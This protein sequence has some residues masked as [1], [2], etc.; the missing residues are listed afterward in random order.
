MERLAGY[1]MTL[2]RIADTIRQREC[3]AAQA[4]ATEG[5][6]CVFQ[7]LFRRLPAHRRDIGQLV[8]GSQGRAAD[9]HPRRRTGDAPARGDPA[10]S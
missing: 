10:T 5:W 9:L 3:R 7:G 1:G 8:V 4:G 6:R 2:D